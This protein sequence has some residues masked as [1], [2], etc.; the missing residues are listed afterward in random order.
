MTTIASPL[1]RRSRTFTALVALVMA[2]VVFLSAC[3]SGHTEGAAQTKPTETV[4]DA[5]GR[6]VE[7]PRDVDRILM[8]G[9]KMLYTTALLNPD[10]PTDKIVAWPED[11]KEN[12]LATYKRYSKEFP[13]ISTI[14]T[15]GEIYN[16]TM[17]LEQALESRPDV[18]VV[19]AGVFDAAKDAGIIDGLEK[20]G[21]PTV[22]VDYFIDPV[23][24]TVPSIRLMGKLLNREDKA[25]EF[26]TYYES[27]V[28]TVTSRLKKA[29]ARRTPT[30]L[31]RAPGYFDCC[32]TFAKSNLAQIVNL[33]GGDNLGDSMIKAKQ[34][35]VSPE[36]LA[37]QNPQV[38]IATGAD[39][40]QGKTPVKSGAYVPLGYD[41]SP[42]A[43]ARDLRAV[44]D[45]Q[46][47]VRKTNAVA[48]KRIY[49]AWHHY[50]DS[51]YNYLAVEMFA[52][53]MH[54]ELFSDIDPDAE[55]RELHDKFLP[56]EATG[57]FW[58]GLK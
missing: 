46:A 36:A 57:T 38:I 18:F 2:A 42:E 21:V 55:V 52:K 17:S 58:T 25:E 28:S 7:V 13:A 43:A 51:P 22:A 10:N 20:A 30:F 3:T 8:G 26:I 4:T 53:A 33:A 15:T 6:K 24:N 44:V 12:D 37:G 29:K 45:K 5:L 49:A 47:A 40:A 50:Y 56:V 35:Q 31:W 48:N 14:P 27:K 34:G 54:P 41:E 19:N 39:W 9:Q 11:L 16:N 23:K 32:S 1:P